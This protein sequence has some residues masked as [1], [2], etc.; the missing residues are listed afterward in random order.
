MAVVRSEN[1]G[2]CACGATIAWV[3]S[4]RGKPYPVDINDGVEK[5]KLGRKSAVVATNDFHSCAYY[6]GLAEFLSRAIER[7]G[8]K[9][10]RI[11]LLTAKNEHVLISWY[12]K[13]FANVTDGKAFD[14]STYYG[15]VSL[16][17]GGFRASDDAPEGLFKLLEALD[18]HPAEAAHAYGK[19][20]GQ[21]CFCDRPL[22][23]E[24]SIAVGYGGT[25]AAKYG[26]PWGNEGETTT[27]RA[28]RTRRAIR[29]ED[30]E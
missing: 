14:D 6:G 4:S 29:L 17:T 18:K 20:T 19:A 5:D 15:S 10:L 16:D 13:P 3:Q 25:C 26:L 9:R 12:G 28:K 1:I 23:D 8:A 22:D 27:K 7:S 11:R 21:C 30:D 24:R 2:Q